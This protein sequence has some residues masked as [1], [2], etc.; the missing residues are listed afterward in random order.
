MDTD[1]IIIPLDK[2]IEGN[3][4]TVITSEQSELQ[5]T[6]ST[7]MET[8]DSESQLSKDS[9][10]LYNCEI[11]EN[12]EDGKNTTETL[13]ATP[14]Q[15]NSSF[16]VT[17]SLN[18]TTDSMV[19]LANGDTHEGFSAHRRRHGRYS[20]NIYVPDIGNKWYDVK[21]KL[22]TR[23]IEPKKLPDAFGYLPIYGRPKSK[24]NLTEY[25]DEKIR[26][27]V[28]FD[29]NDQEFENLAQYCR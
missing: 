2:I 4:V 16:P 24:A 19:K 14:I 27:F 5:S 9:V 29:L 22:V 28:G 6:M 20:T 10:P 17:E 8:N 23:P 18:S 11:P 13:A 21:G 12:G 26:E 7:S 25:Q 3:K 1:N 15:L